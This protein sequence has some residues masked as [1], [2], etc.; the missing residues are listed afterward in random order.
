MTPDPF[1]I[2]EIK[3]GKKVIFSDRLY[4]SHVEDNFQKLKSMAETINDKIKEDLKGTS[5]YKGDATDWVPPLKKQNTDA[6]PTNEISKDDVTAAVN[7][8]INE[9]DP[10][11]DLDIGE[12]TIQ[13]GYV[14]NKDSET[15]LPYID[16]F[17]MKGDEAVGQYGKTD[18]QAL[19][20]PNGIKNLT[21]F[22][23]KFMKKN[24]FNESFK[25]FFFR[26]IG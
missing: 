22:L 20:T 3:K 11:Y 2:L 9:E 18:P 12:F 17:I 19:Q 16:I 23:N 25:G 4:E 7:H 26:T 13:M 21:L 24:H 6:L 5:L 8:V 1:K 10:D 15:D 14:E